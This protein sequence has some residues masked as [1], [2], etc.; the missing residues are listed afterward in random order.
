MTLLAAAM[1]SRSAS[2]QPPPPLPQVALQITTSGVVWDNEGTVSLQTHRGVQSV[3]ASEPLKG[4][5]APELSSDGRSVALRTPAGLLAGTPPS[6]LHAVGG[7]RPTGPGGCRDYGADPTASVP[8][9][10]SAGRLIIAGT[11]VC[12]SQPPHGSL[13]LFARSLS[14][15]R[16][17]VLLRLPTSIAP[18]LAARGHWLAI[19][20][21]L[22]PTSM[23]VEMIDTRS[24]RVR[25]ELDL[26]PA[27][28]AV[29]GNG[30][31]LAAVPTFQSTFPIQA[32]N[33]ANGVGYRL[34]RA[35]PDGRV[36]QIESSTI[37]AAA[38]SDDRVAYLA[39]SPG[40]DATEG[41]DVLDLSSGQ[42]REIIAFSR[43]QRSIF[44]FDLSGSELAWVQSDTTPLP[45]G[46]FTCKNGPFEPVGPRHVVITDINGS[47]PPIPA[48]AEPTAIEPGQYLSRCGPPE[49]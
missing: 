2:A 46:Q 47:T 16:W 19:G 4:R 32:P 1:V 8:V 30:N 22:S 3:L 7:S 27:D 34:L 33:D 10:V 43:P 36:R 31:L 28:L 26:P 17:R 45:P 29:D 15:G 48:P 42:S 39:D 25:Y 12:E 38:I 18:M 24:G 9:V 37:G 6:P 5:L 23:R 13:P 20:I 14:G 21:P 41:L 11:P 44:A 49:A 40:P 35:S